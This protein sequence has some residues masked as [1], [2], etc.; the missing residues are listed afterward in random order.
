LWCGAFLFV[1]AKFESR[2]WCLC[3]EIAM[4]RLVMEKIKI[5]GKEN[6]NESIARH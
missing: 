1:S 3:D 6:I 2:R 5:I 4:K